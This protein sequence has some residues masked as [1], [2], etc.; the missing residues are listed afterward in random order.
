MQ[1]RLMSG[2]SSLRVTTQKVEELECSLTTNRCRVH[3]VLLAIMNFME[4]GPWWWWR[5]LL[6]LCHYSLSCFFPIT[7][8][9]FTHRI[10][11]CHQL[12]TEV[13]EMLLIQHYDFLA[14]R[15]WQRRRRCLFISEQM[16]PRF[17][18]W[19]AHPTTPETNAVLHMLR[20]IVEQKATCEWSRDADNSCCRSPDFSDAQEWTKGLLLGGCVSV[21]SYFF[22]FFSLWDWGLNSRLCAC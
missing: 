10:P 5:S 15:S 13:I 1:N 18:T 9:C 4:M 11:A 17:G 22:F 16:A 19:Y 21:V 8:Y 20:R 14:A 2:S 6:S 12:V 3:S 7:S